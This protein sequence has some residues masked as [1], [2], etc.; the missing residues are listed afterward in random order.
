MPHKSKSSDPSSSS[1]H[2]SKFVNAKVEKRYQGIVVHKSCILEWGFDNLELYMKGQIESWELC[3][4]QPQHGLILVVQVFY[5]N[6]KNTRIWKPMCRATESF[7]T[8]LESIGFKI[9]E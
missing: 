5:T 4:K 6:A 7:L 9:A 2:K 8:K 3:I 1:I